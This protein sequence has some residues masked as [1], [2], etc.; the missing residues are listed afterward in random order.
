VQGS[1]KAYFLHGRPEYLTVLTRSAPTRSKYGECRVVFQIIQRDRS[2]RFDAVIVRINWRSF[3]H[4][5]Q[6]ALSFLSFSVL[7]L[8]SHADTLERS[9]DIALAEILNKMHAVRELLLTFTI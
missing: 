1:T 4:S 5:P 9:L 7:L 6:N 2:K 3:V 8:A